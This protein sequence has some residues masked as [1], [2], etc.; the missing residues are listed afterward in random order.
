MANPNPDPQ[1]D[2]TETARTV[3]KAI[4]DVISSVPG[5]N[6]AL[7]ST[8]RE[9][10]RVISNQSA[11][12]AAAVS[13]TLALPPGPLGVLTL[14]PDLI[15]VW[16]IQAQLVADIGGAYGRTASLT[17]EQMLYCL[18][19]HA[20]VQVARDLG[21]RVGERFIFRPATIRVIQAVAQRLGITVTQ[22]LIAKSVARWLPVLG[23]LGVA[24]YAYYDTGQVAATAIELFESEAQGDEPRTNGASGGDPS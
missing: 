22:R 12:R 17:Q 9:R 14:V 19:R 7:N 11:L 6:E 15:A 13:G 24:A 18:F 2:K 10:A 16:R 3:A 5:T 1:N 23:S 4:L 20:A 21:V 8:P